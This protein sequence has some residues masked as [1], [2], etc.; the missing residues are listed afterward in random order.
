MS[1]IITQA[2]LAFVLDAIR[3]LNTFGATPQASEWI[4]Q[5]VILITMHDGT[6]FRAVK[7]AEHG[8]ALEVDE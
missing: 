3:S 1:R 7:T 8:W 6:E 4:V 2:Q 5:D